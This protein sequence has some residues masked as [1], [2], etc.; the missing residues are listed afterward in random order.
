MC[1]EMSNSDVYETKTSLH[2]QKVNT[3]H[4]G[5]HKSEMA[6][7]LLEVPVLAK[8]SRDVEVRPWGCYFMPSEDLVQELADLI[9]TR[10]VLEIFAGNGLLGACLKGRGV[11]ITVTTL[12][13]SID[14]HD[15]GVYAPAVELDACSAVAKYGAD[16][17]VLLICWPAVT[18]AVLHAIKLWDEVGRGQDVIY[19]GEVTDYGK[20]HLGGC[21][22]DAFFDSMQW[23]TSLGSY[24]VRNEMEQALVGCYSISQ[25]NQSEM[26]G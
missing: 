9:G 5:M 6:M 21:A 16:S 12:Y 11:D 25:V 3:Y 22:T 23:H 13:S 15:A 10:K 7:K 24:R 18:S 8:S 4:L 19:I 26:Q 2:S 14:G 1:L 20:G 17:D